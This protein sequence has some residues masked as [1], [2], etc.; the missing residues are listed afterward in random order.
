MRTSRLCWISSGIGGGGLGGQQNLVLER[1]SDAA[2]LASTSADRNL[3]Q[4]NEVLGFGLGDG[5]SDVA[6]GSASV[7]QR[8]DSGK[9]GASTTGSSFATTIGFGGACSVEASTPPVGHGSG[10]VMIGGFF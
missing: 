1:D 9:T 7:W 4:L 3:D 10:G 2:V 5:D 6:H 8:Q